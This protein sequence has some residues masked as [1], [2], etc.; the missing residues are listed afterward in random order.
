MLYFSLDAITERKKRSLELLNILEEYTLKGFTDVD[1]E[2]AIRWMREN[3]EQLKNNKYNAMDALF[4]YAI[5]ESGDRTEVDLIE[6]LVSQVR[7]AFTDH[8]NQDSI[9]PFLTIEEFIDGYEA[10]GLTSIPIKKKRNKVNAM[11]ELL[12]EEIAEILRDITLDSDIRKL[13]PLINNGKRGMRHRFL[14]TFLRRGVDTIRDL[15]FYKNRGLM[16]RNVGEVMTEILEEIFDI[17]DTKFPEVNIPKDY[18]LAE[19]D[20]AEENQAEDVYEG[21]EEKDE[22]G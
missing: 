21:G 9:Y 17:L 6:N 12:P 5:I 11:A 2:A 22:E 7:I 19:I 1:P 10:N 15:Y 8:N 13:A 16:F 18:S 20:E 14:N 4:A 3:M